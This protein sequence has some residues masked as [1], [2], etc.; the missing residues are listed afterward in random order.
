MAAD[1]ARTPPAEIEPR[2]SLTGRVDTLRADVARPVEPPAWV[3]GS[4]RSFAARRDT[5]P[6]LA[7]RVPL[8]ERGG[9]FAVP[10]SVLGQ[11]PVPYHVK[12]SPDFAGGGFYA[13]AGFGFIGSTEF[14]FSDF[15]GD[16]NLYV[17]TDVFSNSLSDANALVIYNYLPRRVDF[18]AGLFH[19]KNYYSSRVTTLGEELGS[20]RLFSERN[21]GG[22]LTAAYPFDRFHRAELGFIQMFVER[23]FFD[24]VTLQ[25][26]GHEYRSI[27]SPSVSLVGDNALF[28]YY[29]PVNGQR[30][31]LTY[32]PSLGLFSNA[33]TYQTVTFDA[34]RYWD[35]THGY[36]FAGRVL[37]GWSGGRDPQTFS[38]GG[39]STLRGFSD[40]DLL[41]SRVAIVNAEFRFPFIQQLGLVGPVPLGIFNLRGA[42]FS[43]AGVVWNEGQTL[44][45]TRQLEGRRRLADPKLGFGVGIRT[46]LYFMILKVDTGWGTDLVGVSHPRW[47]VSLGPEF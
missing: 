20:P 16:H 30:Y 36:T 34:R 1:T 4:D 32:S 38:V 37:T 39:F 27:T 26:T 18:G 13:S 23:Q 7:T 21:F 33:L 5:V 43:D 8:A 17:A 25:L 35:L 42:L 47:Y 3:A 12:L 29:G 9:P 6:R 45:L 31:N 15:L 22:L 10:D 40:F 46:A 14:V 19:F 11:R 28:G 24:P 2:V 41:G 44:H